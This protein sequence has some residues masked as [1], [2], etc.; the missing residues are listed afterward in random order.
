MIK[1]N[2]AKFIISVILTLLPILVGLILWDRLPEV[3]AT[4]FGVN[5]QP[6]GFSSKGFAVFGM[7]LIL[8]AV[9]I[10]AL[11]VTS[12]DPKRKNI[13]DKPLALLFYVVPLVSNVVMALI[14]TVAL[15][16]GINIS[17]VLSL[18]FGVIF[19]L[20]GNILPKAKQNH[21][22]GLRI[23][24]TLNNEENWNKTHRLS[25]FVFVIAGA[26]LIITSPIGKPF[27]LFPVVFAA[28]LIPI[29]YSYAYYKKH[30]QD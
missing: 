18:L 24:W 29:I 30:K 14:Y 15:G 27:I 6:D 5:N 11:V 25:G 7:P 28:A 13:G 26:L 19:V 9:H 8:L 22:F 16:A 3:I 1:N 23:Y 2:K 21:T 4:H 17:I 20:I 12:R 10:L